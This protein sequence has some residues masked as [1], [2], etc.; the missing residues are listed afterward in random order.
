VLDVNHPL[1]SD[2]GTDQVEI[3][4]DEIREA[5]AKNFDV[6]GFLADIQSGLVTISLQEYQGLSHKV[7]EALRMWRNA[8]AEKSS[9]EK[10]R[11]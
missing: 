9:D 3:S 2:D 10:Q 8:K 1:I 4:K 5:I 6:L 11:N 7:I